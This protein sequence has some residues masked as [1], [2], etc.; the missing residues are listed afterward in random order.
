MT[1]FFHKPP[2]L[3]FLKKC[4]Y[5]FD[6]TWLVA[7]Y[8]YGGRG[9]GGTKFMPV[10]LLGGWKL[11]LKIRT[12]GQF[13]DD[14][15]TCVQFSQKQSVFPQRRTSDCLRVLTRTR[16]YVFVTSQ[17]FVW[18]LHWCLKSVSFG[19]GEDFSIEFIVI[20][21]TKFGPDWHQKWK[22]GNVSGWE[23]APL[24]SP[25]FYCPEETLHLTFL[26]S[27]N[28]G[29]CAARHTGLIYACETF[30]SFFFHLSGCG[31]NT[32]RD[33]HF[34][35]VL[36]GTLFTTHAY[37]WGKPANQLIFWTV[38]Y[39]NFCVLFIHIPTFKKIGLTFRGNVW[40]LKF[41]S[42]FS[43]NIFF[44]IYSTKMFFFKN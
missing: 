36:E 44:Y 21:S 43:C 22:E 39:H 29:F 32:G 37:V 14:F 1:F 18:P 3:R 24:S 27:L 2:F 7:S 17:L 10:A 15:W 6:Q 28:R 35:L 40:F 23:S 34:M 41:L 13:F 20:V 9:L 8:S 30:F 31:L 11:S 12:L 5:D 42:A 33:A 19:L 38:F 25:T 4:P 26:Y 16:G